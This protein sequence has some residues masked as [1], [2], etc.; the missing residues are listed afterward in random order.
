MV[1]NIL[2]NESDRFGN[3]ITILMI[4]INQMVLPSFNKIK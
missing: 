3:E 1:I 4:V 2:I